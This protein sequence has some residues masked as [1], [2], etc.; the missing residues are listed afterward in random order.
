MKQNKR[1]TA[2]VVYRC[3]SDKQRDIYFYIYVDSIRLC[4]KR[5]RTGQGISGNRNV[6]VVR[7]SCL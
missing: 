1:R 4:Q 7:G 5:K 6:R 3:L 2:T